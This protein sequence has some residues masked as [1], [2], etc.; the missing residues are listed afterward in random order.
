MNRRDFIIRTSAGLRAVWPSARTLPASTMTAGNSVGLALRQGET[1]P[2]HPH[3]N[4]PTYHVLG[5]PLRSGSLYPGNENDA[6]AYREAQLLARLQAAGCKAID[7]GDVAIPSFLPHH[8]IPPI[9]SWP[10]P[11]IAWECVRDRIEPY[12][13]QPLH[14]PLLIGCDCSVVVGTTQALMG[15]SAENIHVLYVDGDFDDAAPDARHCQSA[16]SCAVWLLTHESPFWS[17][18]PLRPSQVTLMGWSNPSRSMK[19]AGIGSMSLAQIRRSGIAH[20][21]R[22]TLEAIPAAASILLHFDI[23]VFQKQAL[24]AAYFP[25]PEGLSLAEGKE[26][27]GVLLKDPRI[28][29]I[30]VSEYAALRDLN[31]TYASTLVDL[32][33]EGLRM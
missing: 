31:R 14:V 8:S 26:L 16:A 6:Q 11:R 23:D 12:S 21:A 2:E 20:A 9:R 3:Q 17:S 28:R 7:E 18:P 13:R 15:A 27:L 25:H 19:Q 10:G 22:Q 5:V 29:I 30:E 33:S 32:L 24:P 4:E 1:M